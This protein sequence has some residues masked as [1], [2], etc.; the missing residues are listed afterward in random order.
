MSQQTVSTYNPESVKVVI[1]GTLIE[2]ISEDGVTVEQSAESEVTEGMDSGMTFNYNPSR[3]ATVT[4][5]LR[6]ASRG[7][8]DLN[9][10]REQFESQ[11]RGGGGA[12][13]IAGAVVDTVNRTGV[14]SAEVFFLSKPLASFGTDAGNVEFSLAFCNYDMDIARNL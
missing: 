4:I 8:K 12:P 3:M 14:Y 10:I 1:D 7:A 2:G 13:S 9:A 5:S 6:A 11:L